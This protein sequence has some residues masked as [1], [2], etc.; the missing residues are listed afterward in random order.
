MK[1]LLNHLSHLYLFQEVIR[2]GSF[3]AAATQCDLPRSS[4]SK[5]IQ[6][7]EEH[8]GQRL[9]QRSTRK[10]SLTEAGMSLLQASQPL[11][12]MIEDS[13]RVMEDLDLT[14]SGKVKI[15]SSSLIGQNY[16]LPLFEQ[17]RKQYPNISLELSLSDT[18]V[19]L[20]EEQVDIA[21]RIGDLPSSSLVAR[22]IGEHRW[23]WYASPTYLQE[24][25]APIHPDELKDH[26]C[27]LF[28][29]N[30]ITLDHWFFK[31][32]NGDTKSIKVASQI[33]TDNGQALVEMARLGLG[34][35]MIDPLY[36]QKEVEAKT[37]IPVLTDWSN[38]DTYPINL[39]CLGRNYR[40]RATTSIWEALSLVLNFD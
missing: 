15:S 23:G 7:L 10:L 35:I 19:D 17:L 37:L 25:N 31:Q 2:L 21:I 39:V 36:V 1:S 28:K 34:I 26:Q 6:Q 16:L 33:N 8:I 5:K 29:N 22:K 4:V 20:I 11:K 14:P 27:M 38:P 9:I 32:A 30:S 12:K 3:Q 24:R 40:S 13:Q 18:Y